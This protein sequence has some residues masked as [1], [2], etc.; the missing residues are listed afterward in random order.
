T[1]DPQNNTANDKIYVA[2]AALYRGTVVSIENADKGTIVTLKQADGTDYGCESL[3]FLLSDK[4]KTSFE[5]ELL[6]KGAYL[7]VYY[8]RDMGQSLDSEKLYDAIGVNIYPPAE[9]VNFNGILKEVIPSTD[10]PGHGRLSMIDLSND[11]EV[12]FNYDKENTQFYLNIDNLKEGDKL[13]IFHRGIYTM[14]LPPQ[15]AALEVR[16]FA[17]IKPVV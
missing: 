5:A 15:G 16:M 12:M 1:P 7:E 13:N 3:K 2:D 6:V 17:E 10:K 4:T 11:Q 8:G 14:S 9:M